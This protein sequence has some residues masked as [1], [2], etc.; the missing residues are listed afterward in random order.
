MKKRKCILNGVIA[1]IIS[2][3]IVKILGLVY[4]LYLANKQGFGDAGNAIYNSGYQI[5]ALLL[6]ISSIG[7]PNAVAKLIAEKKFSGDNKEIAKILKSSL[8][9]FSIIGIIGSLVLALSADFISNKLLNIKEAKYTIIALSP[10]IF[11]VCL[12]SVYRGFYNGLNKVNITANSQTIEQI[13]KTV[14]TIILVEIVFVITSANTVAMAAIANFATT[15]ATLC[16]FIYLYR[17][18]NLKDVKV[19]FEKSNVKKILKI[20]IPISLSAILA[21]LNRNIDSI[22]VVRFLKDSIGESQAKIQYGILSGKIDVLTSLPV[23]FVIA[24]AT[25][26]IPKISLLNAQN[27]KYGLKKLGKTYILFT[28]LLVLPCSIGIIAFSDQ[29]LQLLFNNTNGSILLKVSAIAIIFISIEQITHAILQGIGKVFVPTMSLFIGVIIKIILNMTLIRLP[30]S[31][32]IGG[33]VGACIATLICHIVASN[34]SFRVMIKKLNIKIEIFK[35]V[36]K[37]II[38]SCIMLLSLYSSYFLLKGIIIENIAIILAIVIATFM[39]IASIFILKILNQEEL[40]FIP[41]LSKFIKFGQKN[42]IY[43]KK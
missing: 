20:S 16:S 41:I 8:V 6:T 25:T 4:K 43:K 9:I 19:R 12:I 10:A 34:I 15:L 36:L 30:E 27:N 17:K 32:F 31:Y 2:Q 29:I 13:L 38:S 1:L 3:C 26:I 7:V 24:I 5:Y 21:S 22:T 18:N 37:P 42:K 39:Y 40:S 33:T 14:F 35:Y 11:N 28:I 23:S